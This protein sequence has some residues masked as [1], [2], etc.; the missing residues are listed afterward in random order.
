MDIPLDF[1]T[2][3]LDFDERS[4]YERE[5][6]RRLIVLNTPILN[7]LEGVNSSIYITA[8]I[9]IVLTPDHVVTIAAFD[10]PI[11]QRFLD[12]K[13]RN[14]EPSDKASFVLQIMEQNVYLN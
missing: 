5:D 14:F 6:D 13:I 4:R 2:D 9:G 1:L 10:N 7:T 12:N 3:S 8:P 11:L